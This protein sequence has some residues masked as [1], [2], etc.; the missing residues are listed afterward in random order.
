MIVLVTTGCTT[1]ISTFKVDEYSAMMSRGDT[2]GAEALGRRY[3]AELEHQGEARDSIAYMRALAF[4]KLSLIAQQKMTEAELLHQR[5][6]TVIRASCKS[7]LSILCSVNLPILLLDD[8]IWKFKSGMPAK[9][10]LKIIH[11]AE[12]IEKDPMAM[13]LWKTSPNYP[14]YQWRRADAYSTLDMFKEALAAMDEADRYST[15]LSVGIEGTLINKSALAF[16]RAEI[17]LQ[18]AQPDKARLALASINEKLL[19]ELSAVGRSRIE[20]YRLLAECDLQQG[21][22]ESALLTSRKA[23]A[24]ISQ[25]LG[26]A[27]LWSAPLVKLDVPARKAFSVFLRA[28]ARSKAS[29]G[30]TDETF[31]VYQMAKHSSLTSTVLARVES[32]STTP[33]HA[34]LIR[35]R[36]ETKRELELLEYRSDKRRA[37][38]ANV[39]DNQTRA[40]SISLDLERRLVELDKKLKIQT[41]QKKSVSGITLSVDAVAQQL[42]E[43]ETLVAF[44]LMEDGA[45]VWDVNRIGGFFRQLELKPKEISQ[46]VRKLRKSL[47]PS[48][49]NLDQFDFENAYSLFQILLGREQRF[50]SGGHLTI[51][52]DGDL[53]ALPFSTLRTKRSGNLQDESWLINSQSVASSPSLQV[54]IARRQ[55]PTSTVIPKNSFLGIGNPRFSG[56]VS[57][58]ALSSRSLFPLDA[59]QFNLDQPIADQ[60]ILRQV[61]GLPETEQE[62]DQ[63][64]RILGSTNRRL[65]LQADANERNLKTM[66][67]KPYRYLAFATHGVMSSELGGTDQ[68]GLLLTPPLN[69]SVMDDGFL[70]AEE[71]SNF[72]MNADLV[73]LSACNTAAPSGDSR[74]EGFSGLVRAFIHAG[75]RSLLATHW[76]VASDPT[77]LLT[78]GFAN[79]LKPLITHAKAKALQSSMLDLKRQNEFS[80][81]AFWA[82]FELVG[83]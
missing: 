18:S 35:Q 46:K 50:K 17:L 71:I 5:Q 62:I 82:P 36:E 29:P 37:Q 78:V 7:G 51:I 38:N 11:E 72:D 52:P 53:S 32:L 13:G 16:M 40:A 26:A 22:W 57:A 24:E 39:S 58:R 60:R 8:A 48:E 10:V 14:L 68:P 70:S 64:S 65:L 77:V 79:H 45:F 34:A 83:E 3:V 15:L 21:Q 47:D 20:Y 76:A 63:L 75:T 49:T 81:P 66:D 41:D 12:L 67:L 69:A 74:K 23:I 31:R 27:D 9:D 56:A 61:A 73:I 1:I 80:H 44:L 19:N 6:L 42:S 4:L 28:A 59:G 30:L 25:K 54:W 33:E 43:Q 2:A 55:M